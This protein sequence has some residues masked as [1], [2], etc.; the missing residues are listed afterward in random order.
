[1][2]GIG[3]I[4]DWNWGYLWPE[5]GLFMTRIGVIC[6]LNWGYIFLELGLFMGLG[7][8]MTGIGVICDWN[9]YHFLQELGLF[10]TGIWVIYDWKWGYLWLELGLFFLLELGLEDRWRTNVWYNGLLS[11]TLLGYHEKF[12][13]DGQDFQKENKLFCFTFI[14]YS[15]Q[16]NNYLNR[17]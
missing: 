1:M 12:T 17:E 14:I 13:A 6:N 16:L 4:Y 15:Q 9:W 11:T 7:L 8:F 10:M 3:V 2:T 5:L